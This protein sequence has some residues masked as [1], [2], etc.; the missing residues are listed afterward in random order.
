[1]QDEKLPFIG[2]APLP[3]DCQD[4]SQFEW[5]EPKPQPEGGAL[6]KEPAPRKRAGRRK[7]F[8]VVA[9]K[10]RSINRDATPPAP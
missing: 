6:P 8:R 7:S 1:M 10:G 9:E 3:L 2:H 4:L 5:Y